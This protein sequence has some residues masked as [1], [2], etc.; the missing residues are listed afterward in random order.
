VYLEHVLVGQVLEPLFILGEDGLVKGGVAE[1]WE[2][3]SD[4]KELTIFLRKNLKFSNGKALTSEDVKFSL[5]RHLTNEK[6]QSYNYLKVIKTIEIL[7]SSTLKFYLH[8]KYIPF[9][10]TLSRDQLGILPNN[11]SFDPESNEPYIGTGPYRI[12]KE[13]KNWS[14]Q[15]N[16]QYRNQSD[17]KIPK[18]RIDIIDTAKNIYPEKPS[19][20]Y[21]LIP[22]TVK[23]QLVKQFPILQNNYSDSKA[24]SFVQYSFWWLKNVN[25]LLS[26]KV[27]LSKS[28][29]ISKSSK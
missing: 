17:I 21:F 13:K 6:S 12:I 4:H 9:L 7:N 28:T 25:P 11:W 14:L 19:D 5:S 15:E 16:K 2:F 10:L 8:N 22:K 23:E 27:Y 20:L 18:W 24:F 1:K 26:I 3:N 29:S